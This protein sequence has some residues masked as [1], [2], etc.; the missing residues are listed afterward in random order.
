[1]H[2]CEA[3]STLAEPRSP[4]W[5][6]KGRIFLKKLLNSC[7]TCTKLE[8]K[9]FRDPVEAAL[10]YFRVTEALPFSCIGVDFAGPSFVKGEN[11]KM[12]KCYITLF[13]CCN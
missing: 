11:G 7:F 4:F 9:S 3:R 2:H 10:P 13:S 6:V 8:G 12:I 1:M 5:E